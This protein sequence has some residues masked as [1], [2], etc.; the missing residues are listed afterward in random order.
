MIMK[1]FNRLLFTV[2]VP[3]AFISCKG[4][5]SKTNRD[6]VAKDSSHPPKTTTQIIAAKP[7]FRGYKFYAVST[8]LDTTYIRSV[9][10]TKSL[11]KVWIV[12]YDQ[13]IDNWIV[14]TW[15]DS[16][17]NNKVFGDT[18]LTRKSMMPGP[19]GDVIDFYMASSI[20][21]GKTWTSYDPSPA[22]LYCK[23][24]P[25]LSNEVQLLVS[26]DFFNEDHIPSLGIMI[27]WKHP[28][29]ING[30]GITSR[31]DFTNYCSV[32]RKIDRR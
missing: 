26:N 11:K 19:I 30:T 9:S 21:S 20:D 7:I 31:F 22:H 8:Q 25:R 6:T 29:I 16:G 1:K 2:M 13:T 27:Q 3:L 5:I 4:G 28:F 32:T 10:N 18:I 14:K 17:E 24:N 23:G 12:Y 15:I